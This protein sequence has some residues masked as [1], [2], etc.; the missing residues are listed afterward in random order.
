[1]SS[2]AALAVNFPPS[3]TNQPVA[4]SV[5]V[6]SNT[7]FTV[8]AGGTAP[9]AYQWR[10]NTTNN[11]G[12]ATN[13]SLTVTNAQATNAGNYTVVVTNNFGSITSSPAALTVNFAPN[14]TNQPATQ[15]VLV[16][17]NATFTVLAGGTA[18]L[19]YQWRFNTNNILSGAT[20]ASLTI[21]NAQATNAGN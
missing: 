5:I 14:I 9:L 20:S 2:P 7:M 17:S 1:T 10:F 8:T 18:P 6:S 11:L 16:G 15:G 3:I 12:G 19:A 13:A 21:T 4:Q